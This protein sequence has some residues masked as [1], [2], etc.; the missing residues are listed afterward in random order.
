[1]LRP[2]AGRNGVVTRERLR[3]EW[4]NH[5]FGPN[6]LGFDAG[7]IGQIKSIEIVPA[8]SIE[9]DQHQMIALLPLRGVHTP[10]RVL[11]RLDDWA[12]AR[13]A[14]GGQPSKNQRCRQVS[15]SAREPLAENVWSDVSQPN[16]IRAGH[17][18]T[19]NRRSACS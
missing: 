10:A 3:W 18:D 14:T 4:R 9:R 19:V 1:M 12:G 11:C 6:A 7:E 8:K 5:A 2:E 16:G 15:K 13:A 17:G